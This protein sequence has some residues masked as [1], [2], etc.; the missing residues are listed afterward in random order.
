M[1]ARQKEIQGW[2]I[3]LFGP[4]IA[5]KYGQQQ[6]AKWL[7]MPPNTVYTWWEGRHRPRPT[8]RE[9]VVEAGTR[10]GGSMLAPRSQWHGS[11][12]CVLALIGG[13]GMRTKQGRNELAARLGIGEK[14]FAGYWRGT[15][16][17][18]EHR[19]LPKRMMAAARSGPVG[20]SRKVK[21][22]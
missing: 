8:M 12:A 22:R 13:P 4:L 7:L 10:H 11:L 6:L 18:S 17:P 15:H 21:A 1:N 19:G 16:R 2:L 9:M 3:G 20:E 14:T 5:T